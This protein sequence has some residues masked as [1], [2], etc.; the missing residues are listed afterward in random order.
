MYPQ[1]NSL[2]RLRQAFLPL[3]EPAN[4]EINVSEHVHQ[5]FGV[6]IRHKRLNAAHGKKHAL[7]L[8]RRIMLF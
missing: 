8:L 4:R 5:Y 6:D 2:H 1:V 7:A 3:L